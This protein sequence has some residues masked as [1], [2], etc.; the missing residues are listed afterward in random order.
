MSTQHEHEHD[1]AAERAGGA[2]GAPDDTTAGWAGAPRRDATSVSDQEARA[3]LAASAAAGSAAAVSAAAVTDRAVG[4]APGDI[5]RSRDGRVHG[6]PAPQYGEYAPDGWVNPVVVEEQRREQERAAAGVSAGARAGAVQSDTRA[7]R[8]GGTPPRPDRA[9]RAGTDRSRTGGPG[10]L[11]GWRFGKTPVDLLLTL[12]LLA[13]GLVSVVQALSV[14]AVASAVRD[15][16]ERRY[17]ALAD[18]GSLTGAATISAAG[19]LVLFVVVVWWSVVR[20]R[21]TKR[22]FWVPL[23]GGAVATLFSTVVFLVVLMQDSH[24]VAVMM[25]QATGG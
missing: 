23:V 13:M 25:Q 12:V 16:L 2:S 24:F 5:A 6:R 14:G 19:L 10:T 8:P 22:T 15:D 4:S 1:H 3:A 7:R 20:L 18:P 17:T 9:E 11:P 21:A